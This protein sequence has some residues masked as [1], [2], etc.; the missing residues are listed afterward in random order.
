MGII[1]GGR[2]AGNAWYKGGRNANPK[3]EGKG[4]RVKGEG[5]RVNGEDSL[6]LNDE[7]EV[8]E[9][10]FTMHDLLIYEEMF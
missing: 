10:S 7:T 6:D 8:G 3:V 9:V 5:S 4:E 2:L 1:R